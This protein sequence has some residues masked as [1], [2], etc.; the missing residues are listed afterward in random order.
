MGSSGVPKRTKHR[1]WGMV[2]MAALVVGLEACVVELE[3]AMAGKAMVAG[4][5]TAEAYSRNNKCKRRYCKSIHCT[6]LG[7]VGDLGPTHQR[8]QCLSLLESGLPVPIAACG[9]DY[10]SRALRYPALGLVART[11]SPMLCS[12]P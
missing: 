8:L 10:G 7:S 1:A 12:H 6:S 4:E 9:V 5:T 3:A 2:E 11:T